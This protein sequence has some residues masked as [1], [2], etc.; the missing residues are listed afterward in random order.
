MDKINFAPKSQALYKTERKNGWK[1]GI[2]MIT[3]LK[4]SMLRIHGTYSMCSA[5]QMNFQTYAQVI[6]S[7]LKRGYYRKN[8]ITKRISIFF[9]T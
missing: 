9:E 1:R 8:I 6:T 7:V 5:Y 2:D 4:M 3:V